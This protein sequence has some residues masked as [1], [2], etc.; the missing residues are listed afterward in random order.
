MKLTVNGDATKVKSVEKNCP[1]IKFVGLLGVS[2]LG[3]KGPK[4][5]KNLEWQ[6]FRVD[7]VLGQCAW[8]MIHEN[9]ELCLHQL[10]PLFLYIF[11]SV[12]S[13]CLLDNESG[14]DF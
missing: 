3:H 9:F 12:K 13:F 1:P 11:I 5:L 6:T 7:I 4:M 14:S 10:N 2:C 8:S